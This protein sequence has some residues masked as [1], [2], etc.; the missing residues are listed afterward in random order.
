MPTIA[1]HPPLQMFTFEDCFLTSTHISWICLLDLAL[2]HKPCLLVY[3]HAITQP[4]C[5]SVGSKTHWVFWVLLFLHLRAKY[6]QPQLIWLTV[7]LFF[8]SARLQSGPSL[9]NARYGATLGN[10]LVIF[11]T[12]CAKGG[13]DASVLG[14]FQRSWF[15]LGRMFVF[16]TSWVFLDLDIKALCKKTQLKQ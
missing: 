15:R 4:P 8:I 6:T 10:I 5:S 11:H 3:L 14:T 2:Y 16:I 13:I 1:Y 9:E 7:C 12:L